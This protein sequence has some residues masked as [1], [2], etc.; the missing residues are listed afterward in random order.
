[1]FLKKA[2]I[3]KILH[4]AFDDIEEIQNIHECFGVFV[5]IFR[6]KGL[7]FVQDFEFSA[8]GVVANTSCSVDEC[9]LQEKFDEYL[10]NQ[11][12]VS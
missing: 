4:S 5:A 6:R 8:N 10:L 1:M 11:N 7:D 3:V 9:V 12:L 2:D